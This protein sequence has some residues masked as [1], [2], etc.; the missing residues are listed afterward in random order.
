MGTLEEKVHPPEKDFSPRLVGLLRR[1]VLGLLEQMATQ[2]PVDDKTVEHMWQEY[3][4][5]WGVPLREGSHAHGP[6]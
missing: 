5:S 1:I 6:R 4:R 2:G 3:E